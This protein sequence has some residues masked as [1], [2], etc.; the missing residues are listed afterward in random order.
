MHAP[1]TTHLHA[2]KRIFRYLRGT[3]EYGLFLHSTG[4]PT[5][6]IAYLDT[7]WAGCPDG[8]RSTIGYAVFLG[9]NLISWRS[10][11]Q[12]TVSKS[13]TE[14]EYRAVAYTAAETIWLKQLLADLDYFLRRPVT[15]YCDNVSAT[16]PTSNPVQHDRSKHIDVDYHFVRE[17][18]TSGGLRVRHVPTQLQVADIVTKGLSNDLLGK[19][20]VNLS[21]I[22]PSTG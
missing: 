15:L 18:V 13:S 5:I 4:S 8:R 2:L 22:A 3:S 12:P 11:K 1:R 20:R 17:M 21:I 9:K 16:Y 10:K 14:A 6:V 19:Y 7:D